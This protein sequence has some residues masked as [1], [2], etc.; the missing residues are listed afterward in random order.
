MTVIERLS[1]LA[2]Q[3]IQVNKLTSI[4][5]ALLLL[6][7]AD[8]NGCRSGSE[9]EIIFEFRST[10]RKLVAAPTAIATIAEADVVGSGQAV[11]IGGL[12]AG[13]S[14]VVYVAGTSAN[15]VDSVGAER[16]DCVQCIAF[17]GISEVA[18][19]FTMEGNLRVGGGEPV[20][21][22]FDGDIINLSGK[23]Q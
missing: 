14:T 2:L 15:V 8:Q 7:S 23:V 22:L 21:E 16:N 6:C 11:S 13:R 20:S 19:R 18:E 12:N 1:S 5:I 3:H 17:V 9:T 4:R 10:A